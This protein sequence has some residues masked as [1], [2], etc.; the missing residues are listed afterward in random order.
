SNT[1]LCRYTHCDIDGL[2]ATS[3]STACPLAFSMQL[4]NV[5]ASRCAE[6]HGCHRPDLLPYRW[7]GGCHVSAAVPPRAS[8]LAFSSPAPE[9]LSHQAAPLGCRWPPFAVIRGPFLL[10]WLPPYTRL[11]A[12]S[13]LI[14]WTFAPLWPRALCEPDAID[15]S[16][17]HIDGWGVP[18][19]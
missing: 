14:C 7:V 1:D 3:V 12:P 4:R 2:G 19:L 17:R 6:C 9:R 18:R 11:C 8:P 10:F 13:P 5:L 16:R 15:G